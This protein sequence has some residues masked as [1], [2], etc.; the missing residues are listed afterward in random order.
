MRHFERHEGTIVL[1]S[2]KNLG[3]A[4]EC[5]ILGWITAPGCS[6]EREVVNPLGAHPHG[7]RCGYSLFGAPMNS[8]GKF[9]MGSAGHES[10]HEPGTS[11]FD[12]GSTRSAQDH[13]ERTW[14]RR[15]T[16]AMCPPI[17][18]SRT[19]RQGAAQIRE[20]LDA[21]RVRTYVLTIGDSEKDFDRSWHDIAVLWRAWNRKDLVCRDSGRRDGTS[22]FRV[23]VPRIMSK[24]VGKRK[25]ILRMFS[26]KRRAVIPCFYLMRPTPCSQAV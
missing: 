22:L 1:T 10:S 16:R 4:I 14:V 21:C 12:A 9:E 2:S 6:F 24:W 11:S 17:G 3:V 15:G 26:R 20:I 23:S 19:S 18:A 25:R 7:S 13:C 5:W 8:V